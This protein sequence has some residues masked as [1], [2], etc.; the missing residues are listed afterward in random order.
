MRESNPLP[1]AYRASAH[2][3]V[4]P[5]PLEPR[6]GVQP[7]QS[8]TR[9]RLSRRAARLWSSRSVT[10][11]LVAVLQT[12]VFPFHHCCKMERMAGVEPASLVWKTR[13]PAA[14]PHSLFSKLGREGESRTHNAG[15]GDLPRTA[16]IFLP[17]AVPTGIEP[18]PSDRQSDI[19]P[20]DDETLAARDGLEPSSTASETVV[21]AAERSG[22][23]LGCRGV[24][25]T[26]VVRSKGSRLSIRRPG[27]LLAGTQRIE[28]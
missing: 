20:I 9:G 25:R 8:L 14:I 2:P 12:A 19:L 3:D 23:K 28:L 5:Q 26:L 15:F 17:M 1:L 13:A 24:N 16:C 11:R 6:V 27:K 10:I 4:L 18:V 7:P 21:L 22:N